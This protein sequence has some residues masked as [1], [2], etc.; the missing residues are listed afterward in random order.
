MFQVLLRYLPTEILDIIFS[1]IT[2]TK[3][4]FLN[5]TYYVRYNYFIDLL[6]CKKRYESYIRDIIRN[7]CYFVFIYIINRKFDFWKN[8]TKYP[9]KGTIYTN[10]LFFLIYYSNKYNAIKCYNIINQQFVLS[11]LKK[12]WCKSN[13]IRYNKW[14]N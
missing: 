12:K 14:T 11:G 3:K 2:P 13:R 8:Q 5:K 9:Y 6:V 7:D 1:M 4:I 10:Y